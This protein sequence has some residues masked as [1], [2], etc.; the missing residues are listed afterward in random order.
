MA[1]TKT[2]IY[3]RVSTEEQAQE[4]FSVRGQIEK[5]KAYSLIKEWDIYDIY[6]DEGISGK[7]LTERPA[8]NRLIDDIKKGNV[9]NVLV[10]KVDRLTRSTRDLMELVEIFDKHKCSFNSLTESIDTD[11]PSGRMFLKI[12]GIFA[13]FERENIA[14]RKRLGCERKVKEGYTLANYS[15]SYGYTK[16]TGQ[17]VQTIYKEEAKIVKEMFDMY[18]NENLSMSKIARNLNERKVKSKR[19]RIM[20]DAG[21][22]KSVLTN[23]TYIGKVRY[24][25]LDKDRYF[26]TKG[27]HEPIISEKLFN[28][29]QTKISD[30]PKHNKTKRPRED[31]Y[32][33]GVLVCGKCGMK[34][35]THNYACKTDENGV[36]TYKSSYRC[37]NKRYFSK[38]TSCDSSDITHAK[39]EE[40]FLRYIEK[41]NISTEIEGLDLNENEKRQKEIQADLVDCETKLKACKSRKQEILEQYVNQEISLL[42][43][44]AMS[45]VLDKNY[46]AI[47]NE[48][49]KL[50]SKTESPK[51]TVIS[52]EDIMLNLREDW[53]YLSNN[54]KMM[55]L[56]RFVN[57]ITVSVEKERKNSC[58]AVI[59][60]IEFNLSS[61]TPMK[62]LKKIRESKEKKYKVKDISH[63]KHSR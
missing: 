4:G 63:K 14:E 61:Q 58:Y 32:F 54:E 59:K 18:V 47:E 34:F 52:Q 38:E 37:K 53:R 3:V 10:F 5:L 27:H 56:Q 40:A 17:K 35:T 16:I 31:N 60:N 36:K 43:Y 48:I 44:R 39:V 1:V 28:Q 25:L 46:N 23:P 6:A 15:V 41:V 50:K 13:E 24:S 55:F 9:N 49:L 30:I 21:S 33:C 42:E 2:G 7:N 20:W 26:E 12:I 29:A 45:N 22:V 19:G 62:Q 8:I 51:Q 57:K 11:T